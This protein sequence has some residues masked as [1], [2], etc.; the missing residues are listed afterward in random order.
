MANPEF[1]QVQKFLGGVDYPADRDQ[2]IDHARQQGAGEDVL[3]ALEALDDRQYE[4][5]TEVSE[6]V[7][8]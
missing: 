3:S 2:L 6:A 4:D 5:P 8:G 7:T 1:I